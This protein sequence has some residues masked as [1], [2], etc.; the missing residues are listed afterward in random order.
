MRLDDLIS[1]I[2]FKRKQGEGN[3]SLT[4]IENDH[5][6]VNI[7]SLFICIKG[8]TVDGH[9]LAPEAVKNGAVAII[10][11]KPLDVDVPVVIVKSTA[12]VMAQVADQFY[13]HPTQKLN[14]IGITGTNG[15]TTISHLIEKLFKDI[16]QVTGLIGT[17]YTKI[18]NE[19]FETK[20]TTPDSLTLQKTFHSMTEKG[21]ETAVMEVSSHALEMGRVFGC[22]YDIAVFSNLT[23][24]H[25]DY[26]GTMENYRYAKGLLF[27]RMGNAYRDGKPKYAILNADDEA[28]IMY[29]R[30]TAANV[31]T[32]GIHQAADVKAEN[33]RITAQ[34]SSFTLITPAE[35]VEVSLPLIGK[36]NIYNCLAAIAV[37]L[38]SNIP[39]QQIIQSLKEIKGVS[40]RFER[41]YGGQDFTVL[42][43]YSHTPDSL[44]NALK[45]VNEFAEKKVYAIVGCGGDRDKTK[46]PLMAQVACEYSTNPIFTSDNP[47]SEDPESILDD[48]TN[49]VLGKDYK[50]I[51]DRRE[52]IYEAIKQAEPKDVILIAGKGHEDYQIIGKEV[53]HFDDREVAMEA[54][55]EKLNSQQKE[56]RV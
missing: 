37:G 35:K 47:R 46:R 31:V 17:M 15:K 40:G 36:F 54:I 29:E 39:L 10:S 13:G 56:E 53:I 51:T 18:G 21:V 4:S 5:R 3:P 34:G 14:L 19:T 8:Y 50:R 2:P 7:G 20:N 23:Q 32:Y 6:K 22:D 48:M 28:S 55:K 45:T 1:I 25:L 26:H 42:V 9:D 30:A 12:K 33:I 16:N 24:D 41:V 11:E 52:A 27:A 49:G 38:V 43:D 44:E